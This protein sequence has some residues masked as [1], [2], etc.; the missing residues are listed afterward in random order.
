MSVIV[1]DLDGT[2]ADTMPGLTRLAVELLVK[3][4]EEEEPEERY[5]ETIGRSFS[6]QLEVLYPGEKR[7]QT[8]AEIYA[9]EKHAGWINAPLWPLARRVTELLTAGG[10]IVFCASSTEKDLVRRYVLKNRLPVVVAPGEKKL[11]QL[12]QITWR[13]ASDCKLV[14]VSDAVYDGELARETGFEFIGVE[15]TVPK[16][17]FQDAGL[18]SVAGLAEA[19]EQIFE[20]VG[21]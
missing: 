2:L 12:E 20:E 17:V 11:D 18:A 5:L 16:S 21:P 8:V 3:W 14:L 15:H 13:M 19:Y 4:Y 6:D 1:F 7:N 10:G 9:R